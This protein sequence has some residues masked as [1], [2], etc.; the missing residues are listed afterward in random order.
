MD[1]RDFYRT[2]QELLNLPSSLESN[3]RSSISRAY[4]SIFIL[5]QSSVLKQTS[6]QLLLRAQLSTQ[7]G[8]EWVIAALRSSKISEI[9]SIAMHL[10][11]LGRIRKRADYDMS[12]SVQ[13]SDAIR[14]LQNAARLQNAIDSF[15]LQ[16]II[17]YM[18]QHI[19]DL[20]DARS[21]Q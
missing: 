13:I 15:G 5:I 16:K 10:H 6:V 8:H 17:A 11:S 7:L 4:Y 14:E 1:P 19:R 12:V 3:Y 2:A 21:G 9:K 20:A 18:V